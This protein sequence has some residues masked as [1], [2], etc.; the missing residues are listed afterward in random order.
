MDGRDA[1]CRLAPLLTPN[2][3][4]DQGARNMSATDADVAAAA[5]AAVAPAGD[6]R[7]QWLRTDKRRADGVSVAG[8]NRRAAAA[9]P[10]PPPLRRLSAHLLPCHR[11][12]CLCEPRTEDAPPPPKPPTPRCRRRRHASGS[13][14]LK[15]KRR[16]GVFSLLPHYPPGNRLLWSEAVHL[17]KIN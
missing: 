3:G 4:T 13:N 11:E 7:T 9:P 6:P 10:P 1:T 12:C 5:V 16:G 8:S 17:S 2:E 15:S 14:G